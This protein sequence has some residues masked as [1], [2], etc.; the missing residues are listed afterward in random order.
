[1]KSN[2]KTKSLKAKEKVS[3]KKKKSHLEI[4][5]LITKKVSW[6]KKKSHGE[7]KRLTEKQK[8]SRSKK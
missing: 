4:K 8:V 6:Q 3:R 2:E 7:I 1:M 5:S